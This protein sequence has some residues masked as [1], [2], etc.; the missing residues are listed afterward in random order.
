VSY[1][2]PER[3]AVLVCRARRYQL[4]GKLVEAP[5]SFPF[6]ATPKSIPAAALQPVT[7]TIKWPIGTIKWPVAA[8]VT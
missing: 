4:G 7:G 8:A 6:L 1:E 3:A 2:S 5:R